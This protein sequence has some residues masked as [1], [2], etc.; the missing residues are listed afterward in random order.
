MLEPDAQTRRLLA[1][2]RRMQLSRDAHR[3]D[4]PEPVVTESRI[5][6]RR[7]RLHVRR[8]RLQPRPLGDGS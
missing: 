8:L 7:H 1:Q 6:S 3:A 2:E 4:A 5:R